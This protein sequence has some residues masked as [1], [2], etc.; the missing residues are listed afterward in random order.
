MRTY[1]AEIIHAQHHSRAQ[2]SLKAHVHL[3]R[4]RRPVTRGQERRA[5]RHCRIACKQ[6]RDVARIWR[7]R[8]SHE[9]G[10]IGTLEIRDTCSRGYT[11]A[12]AI[13]SRDV[14]KSGSDR[15]T[16]RVA[17][18][19]NRYLTAV[20]KRNR[21]RRAFQAG[22]AI[23]EEGARRQSGRAIEQDVVEYRVVIVDANAR[24]NYGLAVALGIPGNSDLRSQIVIG[25]IDAISESREHGV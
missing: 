12:R 19:R 18:A 6:I 8:G 3:E 15:G 14:R 10:L 4:L 23:L 20:T 17:P 22:Q 11:G 7:V 24:T 1:V 5:G 16:A 2:L 21:K 9:R 25:L 13:S